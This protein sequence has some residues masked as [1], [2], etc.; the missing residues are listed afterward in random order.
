MKRTLALLVGLLMLAAMFSGCTQ[1]PQPTA[2][3]T[4]APTIEAT[5]TP[6]PAPTEQPA[7]VEIVMERPIWGTDNPDSDSSKRIQAAIIKAINVKVTIVGEPNPNDQWQKPNLMLASGEQLDIFQVPPDGIKGW[8][9]YKNDGV[10]IPLNDLLD[11]YGADLKKAVNPVTW[12]F[13]T[14][15]DGKIWALAQEGPATAVDLFIRQDWLDKAGLQIPKTWDEFENVMSVFK[16]QFNDPGIV[17]IWPQSEDCYFLGSFVDHIQDY[18]DANGQMQPFWGQPG[19]KDYLAKLADWYQKGYL[20]KEFTTITYDGATQLM[21]GGKV[22]ICMNWCDSYG[23]PYNEDLIKANVPDAK[24][25]PLA[26]PSGPLPPK[27][28]GGATEAADIM[29]TASSKNPEAAMTYMNYT[30]ATDEGWALVKR[31]QEGIDYTV[32]D[33]SDPNHK[34]VKYIGEAPVGIYRQANCLSMMGKLLT[35]LSGVSSEAFYTDPAKYPVQFAE[36]IAFVP[37]QTT[38]QPLKDALQQL[39]LQKNE[40]RAKIIMGEEPVSKWD[41]MV[42]AYMDGGGTAYYAEL[43]RQFVK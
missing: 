29:I 41:D 3:A 18:K 11:K 22:G 6:E 9:K 16:T 27:A 23:L 31:G 42:K 30:S 19:Y 21:W 35:D 26:P 43:T 24:I 38:L 13:L 39:D 17:P 33:A 7:P 12:P 10:I 2:A 36:M 5:A 32:V 8:R 25:S 4:A 1:T 15:A 40:L 14:D 28:L 20:N 34:L 37:D